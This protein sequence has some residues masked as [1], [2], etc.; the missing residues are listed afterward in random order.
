MGINHEDGCS[1]LT[2]PTIWQGSKERMQ[3]CPECRRSAP[4]EAGAGLT[5]KVR[6]QIP[7]IPRAPRPA[8]T[9]WPTHRAR[10]RLALARRRR[11]ER[12]Q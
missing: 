3:T 2:P 1:Q 6:R 9:G 8:R 5:K 4:A 11:R 7:V 12:T 10:R